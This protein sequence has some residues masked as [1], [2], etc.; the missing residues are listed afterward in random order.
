MGD[1]L[2]TAGR[3]GVVRM[4]D[5]RVGFGNGEVRKW[6]KEG[7]PILSLDGCQKRGL[8]AAGMELGGSGGGGEVV[9][10]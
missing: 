3:D 9:V 6:R 5:P 10:W 8:V 4:W 1:V 7:T 2:L